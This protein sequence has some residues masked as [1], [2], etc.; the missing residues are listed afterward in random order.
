VSIIHLKNQWQRNQEKE[1]LDN[2]LRK[3]SI[4]SSG[5]LSSYS[6]KPMY[7]ML[8]S[9]TVNRILIISF[10]QALFNKKGCI[11]ECSV[12]RHNPPLSMKKIKIKH[13]AKLVNKSKNP[14]NQFINCKCCI[15]IC[16]SMLIKVQI[17]SIIFQLYPGGQFY[18]W[19]KSEYPEKISDFPQVIDKLYHIMLYRVHLAMNRI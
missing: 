5:V 2:I 16:L 13:S 11:I 15:F 10:T 18:W 17:F 8:N 12:K 19:E 9:R 7:V 14:C 3:D 4:L 1:K 6:S